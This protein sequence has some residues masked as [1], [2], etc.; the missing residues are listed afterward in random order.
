MAPGSVG[1]AVLQ[2]SACSPQPAGTQSHCHTEPGPGFKGLRGR[3]E[4][5]H[6]PTALPGA[7]AALAGVLPALPLPW[8]CGEGPALVSV[9]PTP[10]A[11]TLG[12][13]LCH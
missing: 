10:G 2:G 7:T 9:V 3:A 12:S 8:H 1:V 4:H 11:N 13:H 5:Q 6:L